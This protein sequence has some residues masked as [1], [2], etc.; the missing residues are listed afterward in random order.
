MT[1]HTTTKD[2]CDAFAG[3]ETARNIIFDQIADVDGVAMWYPWDEES[4]HPATVASVVNEVLDAWRAVGNIV[5]TDEI[6]ALSEVAAEEGITLPDIEPVIPLPREQVEGW[7]Y[8]NTP[9]AA[10]HAILI[11]SAKVYR[12]E[13][14]YPSLTEALDAIEESLAPVPVLDECLPTEAAEKARALA[15]IKFAREVLRV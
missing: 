4:R 7:L 12:R 5:S 1:T 14:I 8:E 3:C 2:L 9:L 6:A 15:E 11:I 10:P 13:W